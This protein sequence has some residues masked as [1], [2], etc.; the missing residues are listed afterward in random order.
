LMSRFLYRFASQAAEECGFMFTLNQDRLLEQCVGRGVPLVLPGEP[1]QGDNQER[2]SLPDE[3]TVENRRAQFWRDKGP[4]LAYVKLHGSSNWWTQ[5][6]DR[7]LAIGTNKTELLKREPL[8]RWYQELFA[9]TLG[10]AEGA[11]LLVIGYSFRD[12]HINEVIL[13]A[14]EAKRLKLFVVDRKSPEDFKSSVVPGQGRLSVVSRGKEVWESLHAY[15][16]GQVTDYY[17]TRSMQLSPK[18]RELVSD[19]GLSTA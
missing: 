3:S 19:L 9:E 2:E 15:Y 13:T 8:L 17:E 1:P 11:S 16:S 14:V 18:G 5:S 12:P 7:A 10:A 6:G 4:R